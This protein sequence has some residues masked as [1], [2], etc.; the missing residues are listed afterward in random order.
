MNWKGYIKTWGEGGEEKGRPWAPDPALTSEDGCADEVAYKGGGGG[1]GEVAWLVGM[2][3]PASGAGCRSAAGG[4]VV[5]AFP[6]TAA[7]SQLAGRPR[8]RR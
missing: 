3:E 2:K 8:P 5:V 1:T 6:D 4:A 7:A